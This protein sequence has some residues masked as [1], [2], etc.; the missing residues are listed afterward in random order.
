MPIYWGLMRSGALIDVDL[1]RAPPV[2]LND[3]LVAGELDIAPISLLE[4]LRHAEDLLLLPGLAVGSDGP[5]LS[6]NIVHE[7]PLSQLDGGRIALGSSSRTGVLLARLLLEQR[8]GVTTQ[9]LHTEPDIPRMLDQADAAVVIGDVA[10]RAMYEAPQQGL[11]VTDLGAAWRDWTGLPMVFAVWAV[12]REYAAANPGQVKDVHEAFLR[13]VAL[14]LTELDT[15]AESAARWES[16]D[17]S[18]LEG[19]FRTLDFSLGKRQ[20]EGLCAFAAKAAAAAEAPPLPAGGP[21]LW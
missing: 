21:V 13:S 10:L 19:Y 20:L 8:Y 5:V 6:V 11:T 4:Y 9:Y 16:F 7:R 17:A 2:A 14:S 15:V 1:T 18:T 3:M 12:R